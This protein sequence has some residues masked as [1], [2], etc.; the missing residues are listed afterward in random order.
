VKSLREKAD[1]EYTK[2]FAASLEQAISDIQ[3]ARREEQLAREAAERPFPA[4]KQGAQDAL[5]LTIRQLPAPAAI[6]QDIADR[7]KA[8]AAQCQQDKEAAF[9]RLRG[10]TNR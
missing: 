1:K 10:Y 9:A 7:R 2:A 4:A 3:K 5:D 6:E 8:A